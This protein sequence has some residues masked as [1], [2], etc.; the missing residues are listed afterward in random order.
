MF[1]L[2]SLSPSPALTE[3]LVNTGGS[4]CVCL[5]VSGQSELLPI[6]SDF[7]IDC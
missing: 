5:C 6:I 7:E 3:P 1:D 4:A 2:C